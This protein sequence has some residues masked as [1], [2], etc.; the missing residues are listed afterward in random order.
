MVYL[1][2]GQALAQVDLEAIDPHRLRA[3]IYPELLA[4]MSMRPAPWQLMLID[5]CFDPDVPALWEDP[6]RRA[7]FLTAID[8]WLDMAGM[9]TQGALRRL[10]AHTL[11]DV[12]SCLAGREVHGD[13]SVDAVAAALATREED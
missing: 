10:H 7:R 11:R 8:D 9:G 4:A 6:D 1:A 2:G 13:E 5:E 12:R 3:D